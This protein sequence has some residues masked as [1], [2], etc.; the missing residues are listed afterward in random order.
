MMGVMGFAGS[1]LTLSLDV[2]TTAFFTCCLI[3]V[4]I[5]RPRGRKALANASS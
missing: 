4:Q 3:V 1:L 2:L 5:G